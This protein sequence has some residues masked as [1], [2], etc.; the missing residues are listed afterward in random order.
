MIQCSLP[1]RFPSQARQVTRPAAHV[2]L[3]WPCTRML[4][5]ACP[6]RAGRPFLGARRVAASRQQLLRRPLTL[7]AASK[8]GR[9]DQ[10]EDDAFPKLRQE[11]VGHF[12]HVLWL[13][14]RSQYQVFATTI[15]WQPKWLQAAFRQGTL[16]CGSC[17]S[18]SSES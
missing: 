13:F 4:A 6:L 15:A 9:Q 2:Q 18:C 11:Q 12:S 8:P 14:T 7:S 1:G 3:A 5:P 16:P 10:S 17:Q